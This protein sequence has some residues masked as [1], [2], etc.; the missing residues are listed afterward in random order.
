MRLPAYEFPKKVAIEVQEAIEDIRHI[1]NNG[2]YQA[3]IVTSEPQY[4][5]EEGE[6]KIYNAG[7][8]KYVFFYIDGNWY[9]VQLTQGPLP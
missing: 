4:D 7:A 3:G 6:M 5:G 1:L 2:K 8:T 9:Y